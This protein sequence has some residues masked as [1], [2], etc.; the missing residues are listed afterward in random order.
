MMIVRVAMA[1]TALCFSIAPFGQAAQKEKD[2]ASDWTG[3]LH[4]GIVAI[5]GE[6]TG[7]VLDTPKGKFEI[8]PATD[9]VRADLKK[10][11]GQQVIVHGTLAKKP[12]VE[13]KER[14][15]ITVTKV[16][17]APGKG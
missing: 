12:G 9:A 10:L 2:P 6:T 7:I 13:I 16:T 15:I 8:M 1:F 4:L 11:D 3:K 14:S 17:K 5:G